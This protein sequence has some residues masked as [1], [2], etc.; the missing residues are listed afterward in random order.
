VPVE[1][2][3]YEL[4]VGMRQTVMM[5]C[6]QYGCYPVPTT[7]PVT[8]PYYLFFRDGKLDRWGKETF[9]ATSPKKRDRQLHLALTQYKARKKQEMIENS[10]QSFRESTEF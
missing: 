4:L 1:A 3:R 6:G 7:E 9:F 8:E 10:E 2:I 5:I